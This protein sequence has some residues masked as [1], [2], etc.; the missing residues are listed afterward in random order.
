VLAAAALVGG[1]AL[2]RA[3]YPRYIE[4]RASKRRG[5]GVDGIVIGAAPLW[6]DR[7]HA[8]AVL[9]LH[10]AGDTTQAVADMAAHLY[11]SGFAVRAP[12]LAGHGRAL[13]ALRDVRASE[14]HAD[15]D[16]EFDALRATH[17]RVCVVG[18]SMGGALAVTLAARRS[19]VC[20]LVLLA[21]YVDMPPQ[22]RRL[23]QTAR[24]WGPLMPYFSSTT[25]RSI[26]DAAAARAALGYGIFTPQALAA[27]STVVSDA[28][29]ALSRVRT[30]TLVIQSEEDNRISREAAQRAFNRLGAS[31]KA[32]QWTRGA[33][34]VITVDFGH[35]HVFESTVG[36]LAAHCSAKNTSGGQSVK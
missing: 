6:L 19:D 10:G 33:G 11:R 24:W 30:P 4:W 32:L 25:G 1:L 17:A 13:A 27:L 34:H 16:R 5:L 23:A 9:V 31:D 8:T 28:Q 36:W 2:L 3:A 7:P 21:P 26:H 35:E 20:A 12:L 22:L 15:V 29:T 14:W 18:L